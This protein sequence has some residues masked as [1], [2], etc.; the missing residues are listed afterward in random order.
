MLLLE[1][2]SPCRVT[3][4]TAKT[5]SQLKTYCC[6]GGKANPDGCTY[7]LKTTLTPMLAEWET[8]LRSYAAAWNSSRLAVW[9]LDQTNKPFLP[10]NSL[11]LRRKGKSRRLYLSSKNYLVDDSGWVRDSYAAAWDSSRLAAFANLH[12][13]H[14]TI[15]PEPQIKQHL[16]VAKEE[17][18]IETAVPTV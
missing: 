2:V 3:P 10:K 12:L 18:R 7:R 15:E 11:L 16:T 14:K 6:Q 5:W 4:R 13:H 8:L 9:T 1:F 17:R